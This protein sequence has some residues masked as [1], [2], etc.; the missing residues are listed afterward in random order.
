MREWG[1]LA[2]FERL[3]DWPDLFSL[4][5]E[6]AMKHSIHDKLN[7]M[8]SPMADLL[9]RCPAFPPSSVV[10]DRHEQAR[11]AIAMDQNRSHSC[12]TAFQQQSLAHVKTS[13]AAMTRKAACFPQTGGKSAGKNAIAENGT[14][15]RRR[16]ELRGAMKDFACCASISILTGSC[17][18]VR[19]TIGIFRQRSLSVD[20][21]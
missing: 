6:M 13:A 19:R 11:E 9:P 21:V 8:A 15:H 18:T 1:D 17:R 14:L 3:M 16:P 7:E 12:G 5:Q 2:H 4:S 10:R 20:S